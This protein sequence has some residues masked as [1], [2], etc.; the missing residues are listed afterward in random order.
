MIIFGDSLNSGLG[1]TVKDTKTDE[2]LLTISN[3]QYLGCIGDNVYYNKTGIANRVAGYKYY[4]YSAMAYNSATSDLQVCVLNLNTLTETKINFD[5]VTSST[6]WN[7]VGYKVL[8]YGEMMVYTAWGNT[9]SGTKKEQII[10]QIYNT[11]TNTLYDSVNYT[12]TMGNSQTNN[13]ANVCTDQ[14]KNIYIWHFGIYGSSSSGLYSDIYKFDYST[15]TFSKLLSNVSIPSNMD[16]C[17][18]YLTNDDKLFV[19]NGNTK[20]YLDMS[21]GTFNRMTVELANCDNF[22]YVDETPLVRGYIGFDYDTC[23]YYVNNYLGYILLQPSVTDNVIT[24]SGI[25][26][27]SFSFPNSYNM[28][29]T[30]TNYLHWV[31]RKNDKFIISKMCP[32]IPTDTELSIYEECNYPEGEFSVVNTM[33]VE[34]WADQNIQLFT[35]YKLEYPIVT[36]DMQNAEVENGVLKEVEENA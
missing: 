34:N 24:F 22:Y 32:F 20:Y 26:C 15:K 12:K 5:T 16:G 18:G 2:T 14:Y 10:Y 3:A 4:L 8:M 6:S 13:M 17:K 33:N 19:V 9:T 28:N 25:N 1:A 36:L 29:G 31:Y 21:N 23:T 7:W 30:Y 27:V 35:K 11:S